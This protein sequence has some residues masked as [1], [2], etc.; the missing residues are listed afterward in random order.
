LAWTI[1]RASPSLRLLL[2]LT[3]FW[4]SGGALFPHHMNKSLFFFFSHTV[5]SSR[6]PDPPSP[7]TPPPPQAALYFETKLVF[8]SAGVYAVTIFYVFFCP[9]YHPSQIKDF[10]PVSCLSPALSSP[11]G[12]LFRTSSP[13]PPS[14]LWPLACVTQR[15]VNFFSPVCL[16]PVNGNQGVPLLRGGFSYFPSAAA[17]FRWPLSPPSGPPPQRS[18]SPEYL[19]CGSWSS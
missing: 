9:L 18:P 11:P 12:S 5:F 15:S 1:G 17:F 7:E 8:N 6:F 3:F 2:V 10:F 16:V 13:N 14:L 4:P 19:A